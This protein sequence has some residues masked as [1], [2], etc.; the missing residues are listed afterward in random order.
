MR[1]FAMSA[2]EYIGSATAPELI[3]AGCEVLGLAAVRAMIQFTTARSQRRQ[4]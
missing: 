1:I 4:T 3:S 2:T